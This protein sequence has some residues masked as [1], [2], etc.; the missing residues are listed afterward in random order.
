MSEDQVDTEKQRERRDS[1]ADEIDELRHLLI[2]MTEIVAWFRGDNWD[3]EVKA[4]AVSSNARS[5]S[6]IH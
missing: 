5:G 6:L 1:V 2:H 3:D 4:H